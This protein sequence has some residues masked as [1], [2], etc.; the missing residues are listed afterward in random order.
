LLVTSTPA[1]TAI[2]PKI[3]I[4]GGIGAQGSAI[5]RALSAAANYDIKVLTRDISSAAAMEVEGLDN[6]TLVHGNSSNKEDLER[7]FVGIDA[8]GVNT[9][10]FALG[11]KEELFW[12]ITTFEI[13]AAAGVRQYV[14]AGLPYVF[15]RSGYDPRYHVGHL[16]GEG[17]VVGTYPLSHPLRGQA[18]LQ[19]AYC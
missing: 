8:C 11:E 17:R 3:L 9:N 16:D 18:S 5:V 7:A 15:K 14:Y 19:V 6:V 13:A 2:A 12:G 10:G 4:I 1:S